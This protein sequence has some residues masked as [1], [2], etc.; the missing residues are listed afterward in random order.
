M[1]G[2]VAIPISITDDIEIRCAK[3]RRNLDARQIN[4]SL[5]VEPCDHCLEEARSRS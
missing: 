3:C 1:A 4:E 5:Y 2:S